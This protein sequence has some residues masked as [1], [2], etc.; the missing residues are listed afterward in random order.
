MS[1]KEFLTNDIRKR[2]LRKKIDRKQRNSTWNESWTFA[3][4]QICGII[5]FEHIFFYSYNFTRTYTRNRNKIWSK[6]VP[7]IERQGVIVFLK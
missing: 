4:L 3:G 6:K 2:L 7:C 1:E 5:A